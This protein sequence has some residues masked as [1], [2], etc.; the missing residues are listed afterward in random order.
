MTA[1][2]Y[3]NQ[4]SEPAD[5]GAGQMTPELH[6]EWGRQRLV[7]DGFSDDLKDALRRKAEAGSWMAGNM[8]HLSEIEWDGLVGDQPFAYG[9][10]VFHHD[11]YAARADIFMRGPDRDES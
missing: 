7:G 3:A 4:E 10:A 8:L 6:R 2:N 11:K 5:L 9:P 1:E